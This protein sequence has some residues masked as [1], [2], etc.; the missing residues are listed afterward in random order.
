MT[1]SV[2]R[3]KADLDYLQA[4]V[5][6]ASVIHPMTKNLHATIVEDEG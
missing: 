4:G 6:S 1:A 2:M 5:N 3:A